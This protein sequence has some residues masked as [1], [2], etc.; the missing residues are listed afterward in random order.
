MRSLIPWRK[1]RTE[2]AK[3]GELIPFGD[4]PFSLSRMRDEFDR[5]FDRMAREFSALAGWG[6]EGWRW[7]LEVEDQ[8]D[9]I[10]VRAEAPGFEAGDFDV[11]VEDGRLVLSAS[12]K[13]E[14]KDEKGQVKE[15]RAQE[16][17]ESVALPVG[18]DK[19]KA[20]ARYHNGVLTITLPKTAEGKAK[21][22]AVK[23]D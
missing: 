12:K 17:Y 19:D 14:T 3:G 5:L 15:Y 2:P 1:R 11:R 18:I 13:V 20:D 10:I 7:G 22:I 21:K 4:F 8:D 16:C 6:G 23:A 9:S